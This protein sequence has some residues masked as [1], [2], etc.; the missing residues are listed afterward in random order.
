MRRA[1]VI[2]IAALSI[3]I[4]GC[5]SSGSSS[6]STSEPGGQGSTTSSIP[7]SGAGSTST[8]GTATTVTTEQTL[9]SAITQAL[10]AENV[11]EKTYETVIAALG[12]IS[13]FVNVFASEQQ[14]VATLEQLA[15]NHSMAVPTGPFSVPSAP[16]TKSGACELGV[17][18]E[19]GIVSLY[20]QLLPQVTADPNATNV[21]STMQSVAQ[22]D[23]LPAFQHCA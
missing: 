16:K 7:P 20:A 8:G 22:D 17:T 10:V 14:H 19:H 21:F 3:T 12:S 6:S 11:A 13:P 15:R 1:A 9:G 18:T 4:A 2:V 5:G 23:H